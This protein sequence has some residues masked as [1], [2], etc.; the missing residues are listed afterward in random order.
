MTGP[1][2]SPGVTNGGAAI[3]Q[4]DHVA[5][6]VHDLDERIAFYTVTLG[7]KLGRIG[8][9]VKTGGRIAM[10]ADSNGFKLELIELPN[11]EPGFQHL[12]YRVEDVEAAH[13]SLVEQGCKTIRGPHEIG[14]AKAVTALV[15]DPSGTQIQVIKY[16]PDSP[17]L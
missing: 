17:D 2:N 13:A 14:A 4:L 10:I 15:E 16:A 8:K 5:L 11:D 12:A 6:G 1:S 3:G 7:M 9:H